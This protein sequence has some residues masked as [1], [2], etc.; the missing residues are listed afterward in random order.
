MQAALQLH[1]L[2]LLVSGAEPCPSK[3]PNVKPGNVPAAE[4]K[5]EKNEH[6]DRLLRDQAAQGLMKGAC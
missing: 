2:W 6:L 1:F 3:S 5:V 4:W